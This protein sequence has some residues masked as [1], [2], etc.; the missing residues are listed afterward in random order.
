M[1]V[2]P[3]VDSLLKNPGDSCSMA[4]YPPMT[5]T[6]ADLPQ[7]APDEMVVYKTTAGGTRRVVTKRDDDLLTA[8]EMQEN[9]KDVEASMLKELLTWAK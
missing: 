2:V 9:R 1:T 8:E 6:I 7:I 4:V 5:R 3:P